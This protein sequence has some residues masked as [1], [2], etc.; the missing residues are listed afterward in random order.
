MTARVNWK[1]V[2]GAFPGPWHTGLGICVFIVL[3]AVL[4]V[5]SASDPVD[6][7][8]A[9]AFFAMGWWLILGHHLCLLICDMVAMRLPGIRQTLLLGIGTH[10]ILS[11]GLPL[12]MLALWTERPADLDIFV[13]GASAWL[14]STVG[15]LAVSLP[16]MLPVV[17]V[18]I[19]CVSIFGADWPILVDPAYSLPLGSVALLAAALAWRW[20]TAAARS[21]YFLPLGVW[22]VRTPS[23]DSSS[24]ASRANK[25]EATPPM[26]LPDKLAAM[27]GPNGQTLRQR[28]GRRTQQLTYAVIGLGTPLAVVIWPHFF[29]VGGVRKEFFLAVM[30]FYML[31]MAVNLSAYSLSV[32]RKTLRAELLLTP[33]MP[34]LHHLPAALMRQIVITQAER[35]TLMTVAL[36]GLGML[37]YD[38]NLRGLTGWLCLALL[39]GIHGAA[40]AWLFWRGKGLHPAWA[41]CTAL[42]AVLGMVTNV[43][44]LSQGRALPNSGWW[45]WAGVIALASLVF[46]VLHTRSDRL[47]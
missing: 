38:P 47:Q 17:A 13:A 9:L 28:S 35:L 43:R 23:G 25:S 31:A 42:L 14:G 33:G 24:R 10:L 1:T 6:S 19:G 44:L 20:Q 34:S 32:A 2:R 12:L 40:T 46:W 45:A 8:M 18:L 21:T 26:T 15:L 16:M 29:P 4:G 5:V 27:L 7:V 30:M 36:G 3:L 37:A 22:M 39:I 41:G 11:V